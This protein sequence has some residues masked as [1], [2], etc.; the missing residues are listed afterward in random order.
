MIHI[1]S[2]SRPCVPSGRVRCLWGWFM[3]ML[4]CHWP[5]PTYAARWH[6]GSMSPY[7]SYKFINCPTLLNGA[8]NS[9]L[10]RELKNGPYNQFGSRKNNYKY[11]APYTVWPGFKSIGFIIG[12]TVPYNLKAISYNVCNFIFVNFVFRVYFEVFF[13]KLSYTDFMKAFRFCHIWVESLNFR[14]FGR[15]G[16]Y[17]GWNCL[18]RLSDSRSWSNF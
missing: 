18:N 1:I 6:T 13:I 5:K 16:V 3:K 12:P 17:I 8:A 7:E 14:S 2:T 15:Q 9:F 4:S 10:P 11:P